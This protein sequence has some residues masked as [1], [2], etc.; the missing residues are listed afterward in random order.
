MKDISEDK[1]AT[2]TLSVGTP[3]YVAPEIIKGK[4]LE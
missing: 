3:Y 4:Q 1:A 2:K